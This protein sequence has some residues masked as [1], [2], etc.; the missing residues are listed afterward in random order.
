MKKLLAA[1]IVLFVLMLVLA[2]LACISGVNGD[3]NLNG[4]HYSDQQATLSAE[5]TATFGVEQ[6]YIQLTAIANPQGSQ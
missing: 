3:Q 4:N 5:V 2:A 1:R 6:L